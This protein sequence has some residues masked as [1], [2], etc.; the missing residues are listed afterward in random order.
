M[1]DGQTGSDVELYV[2]TEGNRL[3]KACYDKYYAVE[4]NICGEHLYEDS[5]NYAGYENGTFDFYYHD[6]DEKPICEECW[7]NV[8]KEQCPI[9]EEFLERYTDTKENAFFILCQE[10]EGYKKGMYKVKSFPFY[11]GN[12]VY[13]FENFFD[14]AIELIHE[15]E[16]VQTAF[17]LEEN[18]DL[19][20]VL[21]FICPDC[22]KIIGK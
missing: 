20:P 15:W 7:R 10:Y 6:E 17:D 3:C 8:F 5:S 21:Y 4:C 12:I 19:P 1:T 11:Y 13:G 9:C 14:D 22:M 2:N 16:K 18:D